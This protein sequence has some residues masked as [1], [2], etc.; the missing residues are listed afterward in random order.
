MRRLGATALVLALAATGCAR[1][2]VVPVPLPGVPNGSACLEAFAAD[3]RAIAAAGTTDGGFTRVAGFPWL[4]V[5]RVLASVLEPGL[6]PAER[7]AWLAHAS[8]HDRAAR[9]AERRNA[10]FPTP[11]PVL[12]A[13][14]APLAN[15]LARDDDAWLRLVEAA[16]DVPDDYQRWKRVL[17]AYPLAARFVLAGVKRLHA[18][19]TPVAGPL[20]GATPV[21]LHYAPERVAPRRAQAPRIVPRDA[22]GFPVPDAA[23]RRAL[24][25]LHAPRLAVETR[26]TFDRVGSFSRDGGRIALDVEQPA[27]Y[28]QTTHTRFG[29]AV[30]LQLVYTAWFPARPKSGPLDLYGGRYDALTWRVT[31]D[32]DGEPLLYDVMHACGCYHMF[33]PTRRL[34][35]RAHRAGLE[36]PPWVPFTVPGNWENPLTV[37]LDTRT[38]YVRRIAPAGNRPPDAVLALAPYPNLRS[39]PDEQGRARSLFDRHGIV[40]ES[41]RLERWVLWPMGIRSAGAMRQLGR[42]PTAFVGRRHF[43]D[44]RLIERYFERAR[45]AD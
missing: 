13:C 25:A 43:D 1:M 40:Q 8:A 12:E 17:G 4:R 11:S 3:D 45:P 10:A 33:F 14:R 19:E 23:T 5:N 16:R 27:L 21:T 37:H 42:H 20:D 35:R 38:H 28:T 2:A 18:R 30:L 22:L 29:E 32:T 24:L 15:A 39:I 7:D 44:A 6:G 31:L 26:G 36:E 34:A 41:R 9:G